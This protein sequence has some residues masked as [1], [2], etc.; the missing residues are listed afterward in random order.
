MKGKLFVYLS[1]FAVVCVILGNLF[2]TWVFLVGTLSSLA[3]FVIAG[4]SLPPDDINVKVE[5]KTSK[6][7]KEVYVEDEFEVTIKLENRGE[8]LRFLEVHDILPSLVDVIKGSNHHILSLDMG[9]E[10]ELTYKISCPVTG[11]I[12]IGPVK[13]RYRDSFG[14]FSKELEPRKK[15]RVQVLPRTQDMDKV[16]INPTYTKHWLGNIKSRSI[17]IGSDFFSLREYHPGDEIRDINWKATARYQEP[18]T[19]EYEGEKSGDVILVVDGYQEGVVGTRRNSTLRASIDAA[20]TLASSALSARNRVGLIV[21]GEYLNW[22]YPGT[23]KNQY[24]KILANLT[25]FERGGTWGLKGVRWL[26]EDFFP[27]RSLIIF[28][29]PLTVPKFSETIVDLCRKEYDIMVISP[30]PIKIE[31]DII[32][33]YEDAVERLYRT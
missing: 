11:K 8:E 24:H 21:A 20:A 13:M 17:G 33:D 1:V 28:I 18:F 12:D 31:K 2:R 32:D 7:V 14:F 23:G 10:K 6:R 27:N 9:E 29:S 19:N 4:R 16:D 15:L 5:R 22:V 3:L 26:L 30:D 25:K